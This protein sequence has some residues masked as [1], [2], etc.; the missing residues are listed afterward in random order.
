M[1]EAG[2][3]TFTPLPPPRTRLQAVPVDFTRL[4]TG[5]L[6]ARQVMEHPPT[7]FITNHQ[8]MPLVSDLPCWFCEP[9]TGVE[10]MG[11]ADVKL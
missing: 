8:N 7:K 2:P 4:E 9:S 1:Q 5:H 10:N 6:P 11:A 3:V